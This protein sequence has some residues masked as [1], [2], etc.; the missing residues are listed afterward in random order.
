MGAHTL[1][2]TL[3]HRLWDQRKPSL[4]SSSRKLSFTKSCIEDTFQKRENNFLHYFPHQIQSISYLVLPHFSFS[5]ELVPRHSLSLRLIREV[6]PQKLC[7]V[8]R[9][10]R[11]RGRKKNNEN[12]HNYLK[13][14]C[15]KTAYN[16]MIRIVCEN[17]TIYYLYRKQSPYDCH[18]EFQMKNHK[19]KLN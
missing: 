11:K 18:Y 5:N 13:K 12:Q 1:Q 16:Y 7:I 15:N 2:V 14:S 10:R 6:R 3:I 4:H 19:S 9:R 17:R 8:I